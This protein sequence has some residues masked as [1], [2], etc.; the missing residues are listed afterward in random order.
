MQAFYL[1]ALY[2]KHLLTLTI[3]LP[4]VLVLG[5]VSGFISG[6]SA[7]PVVGR[8]MLPVKRWIQDT[9]IRYL[10]IPGSM[11]GMEERP[12]YLNRVRDIV[13]APFPDERR[14]DDYMITKIDHHFRSDTEI[15]LPR[16]TTTLCIAMMGN[17]VPFPYLQK[18]NRIYLPHV[19]NRLLSDGGMQARVEYYARFIQAVLAKHPQITTLYLDGQS[20]GGGILAQVVTHLSRE[21]VLAQ[22]HVQLRLDRTFDNFSHA[23]SGFLGHGVPRLVLYAIYA[24]FDFNIDTKKAIAEYSAGSD[25]IHTIVTASTDDILLQDAV[26]SYAHLPKNTIEELVDIG[27]N[28]YGMAHYKGHVHNPGMPIRYFRSIWYAADLMIMLTALQ[29]SGGLSAASIALYAGIPPIVPLALYLGA[30]VLLA[31]H[32]Y[33]ANALSD[34]WQEVHD[35]RDMQELIQMKHHYKTECAV[36]ISTF[37]LGGGLMLT[38]PMG[39]SPLMMVIGVVLSST[40]L[41][42]GTRWWMHHQSEKL[43]PHRGMQSGYQEQMA[44]NFSR[45]FKPYPPNNSR[46]SAPDDRRGNRRDPSR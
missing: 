34:A 26:L 46:A 18:N 32:V 10:L 39:I 24:L 11:Q 8:Y 3:I 12:Y 17:G 38:L 9:L 43:L 20:L 22:K 40:A 42:I 45:D 6:L 13:L 37:L 30:M 44:E 35:L 16:D 31:H 1:T 21:G 36:F 5:M 27:H 2:I 33:H 19:D 7:I 4:L 25:N 14:G 29:F 41:L 15:T 28:D 23:S